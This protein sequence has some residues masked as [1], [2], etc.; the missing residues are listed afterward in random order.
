MGDVIQIFMTSDRRL[1]QVSFKENAV[2]SEFIIN[3]LTNHFRKKLTHHHAFVTLWK[4]KPM[5]KLN[6]QYFTNNWWQSLNYRPRLMNQISAMS[7]FDVHICDLQDYLS[8]ANVRS[9]QLFLWRQLHLPVHSTIPSPAHL[10]T[11]I[12]KWISKAMSKNKKRC[13]PEKIELFQKEP[14]ACLSS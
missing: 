13:S 2:C 10:E 8:C 4:T 1:N 3:W 6:V 5:M 11:V 9:P 7:L 14:G 12:L